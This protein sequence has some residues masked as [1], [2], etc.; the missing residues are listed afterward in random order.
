MSAPLIARSPDLQ[1][2]V[3]EGYELEIR[4]GHLLVHHVPYV[5]GAKKVRFGTLITTLMLAGE[6][7]TTPDTHVAF[8]ACAEAGEVPHTRE[9]KAYPHIIG[10]RHELAKGVVA[11]HQFSTKP[12]PRDAYADYHEKVTTYIAALGQA[13]TLIEPEATAKTFRVRE[14]GETASVHVYT[15]SASGRAGI[16]AIQSKLA[17]HKIAIVGL[18][19]TGAYVLDLVVKAPVAEIH[20]F[21]RDKYH[22]HTAFRAP[23]A[24]ALED[25]EKLQVKVAY[26]H[27]KY[28]KMHKHIV[29]HA[30]HVTEENV[31]KLRGM[32]FVF[33]T[34]EGPAKKL[35]MDKLHEWGIPFVD[36]G[37][38]VFKKEDKLGG[39]VRI[40]TS[41]PTKRDHI[42]KRV[43]F[44]AV[45]E[46]NEY[47]SNIQVAEL[48]ML[49]ASLAVI[50]WKK[51]LGFYHDLEREHQ[52]AYAIDGNHLLNEDQA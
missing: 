43:G 7:T 31:E 30:E 4:A 32:D 10:G 17:G 26:Y 12:K 20:L 37:I 45:D 9:G 50:K 1:K 33:I 22:Q 5:N 13:A 27:E 3:A 46:D 36:T 16:A 15:E 48:N 19:G 24:A 52:A 38:G 21:D 44:G 34:M 18:G 42:E 29:P 39:L 51:L 41:L 25:L 11:D 6:R 49:N 47:S 23:G 28:S 2:L 40:T 35:I 14:N 8:L